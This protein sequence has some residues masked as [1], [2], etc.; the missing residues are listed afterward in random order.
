MLRIL[1]KSGDEIDD[2]PWNVLKFEKSPNAETLAMEI[3]AMVRFFKK[4]LEEKYGVTNFGWK[5]IV[6]MMTDTT[7]F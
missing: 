4:Q 7:S 3:I 1:D 6:F 5:N 2:I